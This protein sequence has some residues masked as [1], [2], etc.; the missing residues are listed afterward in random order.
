VPLGICSDDRAGVGVVSF[1]E[2]HLCLHF[3]N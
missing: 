3:L 2:A 1:C